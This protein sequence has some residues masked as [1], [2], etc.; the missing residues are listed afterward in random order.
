MNALHALIQKNTVDKVL[1]QTSLLSS[2]DF[3]WFKNQQQGHILD[4]SALN[5]Y[6][7]NLKWRHQR[8]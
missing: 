7:R 2:T 4:L 6:Q 5:K 3:S 8:A 1:T